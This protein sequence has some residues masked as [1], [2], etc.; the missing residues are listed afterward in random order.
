MS[1]C[2]SS[3]THFSEEK[4]RSTSQEVAG[5]AKTRRTMVYNKGNVSEIPSHQLKM[6][7]L[8]VA[9][10]AGNFQEAG[11]YPFP[12]R[13][14]QHFHG[15]ILHT[16]TVMNMLHGIGVRERGTNSI[17]KWGVVDKGA[18]FYHPMLIMSPHL[19]LRPPLLFSPISPH[20]PPFFLGS[21]HQSTPHIALLPIKTMLF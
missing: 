15:N 2:R 13:I 3:R 11:R 18:L 20:F 1:C 8:S 9:T 12:L 4:Q 14:P 19:P 6:L 7:K 17:C 10:T 21:F 16:I 5:T